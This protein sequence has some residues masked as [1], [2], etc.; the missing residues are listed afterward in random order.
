V[1]AF[2]DQVVDAA[3]RQIRAHD[4]GLGVVGVDKR[5]QTVDRSR[6]SGSPLSLPLDCVAT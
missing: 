2:L 5:G 1:Q 6:K 4:D 3:R